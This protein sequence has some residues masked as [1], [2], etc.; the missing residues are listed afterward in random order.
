MSYQSLKGI[1]EKKASPGWSESNHMSPPPR[2]LSWLPGGQALISQQPGREQMANSRS[3]KVRKLVPRL[4]VGPGSYLA[5]RLLPPHPWA[6]GKWKGRDQD[7][8]GQ[9]RTCQSIKLSKE[10]LGGGGRA[11]NLNCLVPSIFVPYHCCGLPC[12]GGLDGKESACNAGDL[13]LIPELRRFPWRRTWQPTP[14][15]LPGESHGQRSLVGYSPW[16]H[17]ELDMTERLST[18]HNPAAI[19][20][21]K[22]QTKT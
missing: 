22:N 18:Q 6:Q 14:V 4:F 8:R 21:Y 9:G 12:P 15:F 2:C 1:Q 3:C 20:N 19:T 17:K 7:V 13:S 10:E 5:T 16:G 11:P